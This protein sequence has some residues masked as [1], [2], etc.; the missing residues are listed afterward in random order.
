MCIISLFFSFAGAIS[1]SEPHRDA[2]L[3][4]ES[5][6]LFKMV[7]ICLPMSFLRDIK[8]QSSRMSSSC[9]LVTSFGKSAPV[10]VMGS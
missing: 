7:L 5:R 6:M 2:S 1:F 8:T 3:G 9:M 4:R 10:T